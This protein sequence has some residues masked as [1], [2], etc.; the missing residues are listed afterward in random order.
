MIFYSKRELKIL[1][2]MAMEKNMNASY[3]SG[4]LFKES[5]YLSLDRPHREGDSIVSKQRSCKEVYEVLIS[6]YEYFSIDAPLIKKMMSEMSLDEMPLF[7]GDPSL[8]IVA[9]WRLRLGK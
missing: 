6:Y 9:R 2:E 1:Y 8:G 4:V 7:I 3:W 5:M